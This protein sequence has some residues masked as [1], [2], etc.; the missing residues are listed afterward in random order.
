L[1]VLDDELADPDVK[2]VI[3]SQWLRSHELMSRALDHSGHGYVLFHGG[4]PGRQRGQLVRRFKTDPACRVF[5]STDAGGVG[6]NLQCASVVMN[7]D[8]PWNPAVL[9]QRIGRAHRLGQHRPVQVLNFVAEASIEHRLMG[10]LEFKQS[11]AAG[12]LDGGDKEVHL[13]GSRLTRFME[14]VERVS[15]QPAAESAPLARVDPPAV[16]ATDGEP[17]KA[18]GDNISNRRSG[19]DVEHA[20]DAW[21]PLL[22]LAQT[23]LTE[24]VQP[25]GRGEDRSSGRL[26]RCDPKT[27][28][29]YLHLPVPDEDKMA[30]LL[31]ALRDVLGT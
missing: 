13:G 3:F 10:L 21:Q 7:L 9:E 8:L 19:R 14:S 11:L 20:R 22:A 4:V 12:V 17:A 5:L 26:V 31:N 15:A 29:R 1:R 27:G 6:L 18:A 25:P 30:R 28:E 24:M 23:L 2:V 16:G